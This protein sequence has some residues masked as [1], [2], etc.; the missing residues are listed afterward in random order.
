VWQKHLLQ[1]NTKQV[2]KSFVPFIS[3]Q[4]IQ[5]A[6]SRHFS[7]INFSALYFPVVNVT[8]F[9]R[10]PWVAGEARARLLPATLDFVR[11]R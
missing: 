10:Q 1:K 5:D 6:E 8:E 9:R 2:L 3:L 4:R 11:V 7:A